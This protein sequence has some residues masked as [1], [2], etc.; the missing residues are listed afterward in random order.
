MVLLWENTSGISL[1][2]VSQRRTLLGAITLSLLVLFQLMSCTDI[3]NQMIFHSWPPTLTC[4]TTLTTPTVNGVTTMT[5]NAFSS[6][7]CTQL[8]PNKNSPSATPASAMLISTLITAFVR[9]A[10]RMSRECHS[11]YRLVRSSTPRVNRL[12]SSNTGL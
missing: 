4:L 9:L 5:R 7:P 8:K 6:K 11:I 10:T 1:R 3:R 12:F 2:S